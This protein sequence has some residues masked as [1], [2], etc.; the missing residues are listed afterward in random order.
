[1]SFGTVLSAA[2]HG[3]EVK[4][5]QVEADLSNGLP[6]FH[7]VGYLSTEVKE[8]GERVRTAIRNSGI[9]LPAKR[10]VINLSPGNDRKRGTSF[11][12]PIAL[13]I[14]VSLGIIEEALLEHTL[15]IGELSLD[16]K[17]RKVPGILPIVDAARK[18][19][20][21]RCILPRENMREGALIEGIE[22]TGTHT[23]REL[24]QCLSGSRKFPETEE[25]EPSPCNNMP[26]TKGLD[27]CEIKGQEGVKRAAEVA[28]AGGH[29][30]LLLGPPGSGKSMIAKRIPSILPSLTVEESM[31]ITKIYSITGL[32]EN[33]YP[34]ITKRPFR[35]VHHTVSRA[36]LI[37]GGTVP[38]PGEITLA[39][40]GVLFLDELTEFKRSVLEVLRQPLEERKI[41]LIRN[42]GTYIY[43]ADFM[44]IAA[45]NPCPCGNYP[46]YEKCTCTPSQ[47]QNYIG[48]ISQP[49]LDRIDI[50][51]ESPKVQYE[52]LHNGSG[53]EP[54]EQIRERVCR[55]R[56][57]QTKRYAGISAR[58][59]GA[60]SPDEIQTYCILDSGVEE[61]VRKA[62][63]ALDLTA[64]TYHKILKV[65]RTIAD[66]DGAEKI[67][68]MH[69][70]EAI[71]YRTLDKKYWGRE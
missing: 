71:G 47:I 25:K 44:M 13:A 31:E 26:D 23:L 43:P 3:L 45:A 55:A 27:F 63:D 66:L 36:A 60:L 51:I 64:R 30:L 39:N 61:I 20:C 28:V 57:I 32:L 68:K 7:M 8:A 62:F 69:L 34:L 46:D 41:Q 19:G 65:A 6:M 59:N 21:K 42:Q 9:Q 37:G 54:S 2:L 38:K 18:R 22:V 48:K 14:L 12:L 50:C 52:A 49:F 70:R 10:T 1:M 35:E 11:D 29:N 58:S 17:I 67:Q 56:E 16:G 15:V 53:S 5:I 24:L 40:G 4:F 33:E